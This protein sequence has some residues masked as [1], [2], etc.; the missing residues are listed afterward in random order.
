MIW[1]LCLGF[2]SGSTYMAM[3]GI[4]NLPMKMWI[5]WAVDGFVLFLIGGAAMGWAAEKWGG[6]KA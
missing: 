4:F 2:L 1:G 3:S 6:L 5:W